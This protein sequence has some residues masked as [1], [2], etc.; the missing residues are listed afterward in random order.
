M[1][2]VCAAHCVPQEGA[3]KTG[4]WPAT[5]TISGTRPR[6]PHGHGCE[7]L[8]L[9]EQLRRA[10]RIGMRTDLPSNVIAP[11]VKWRLGAIRRARAI[12]PGGWTAPPA[13]GLA[14]PSIEGSR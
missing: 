1:P 14:E 6:S 12:T 9:L 2:H 10:S 8:R 13:I 4:G 5:I 3:G 11:S 7:S